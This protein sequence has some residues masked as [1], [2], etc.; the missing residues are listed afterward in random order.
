M[1]KK[2]GVGVLL[3]LL[4]G[5]STGILWANPLDLSEPYLLSWGG[6]LYDDWSLVVNIRPPKTIHPSYPATGSQKGAATWRCKE[7]HGWDYLG[8]AGRFAT[9]EHATGIR[10]I[11][12]WR[13]RDP[14]DVVALLRNAN[15]GYT[16]EMIS[17]AAAHALGL[18]VS[19]GQVEM[20]LFIDEKGKAK[21]DPERGK[22][23]FQTICAFCHGMDG[24]KINFGTEKKPEYLG[25][26]ARDNPWEVI[27]KMRHGEPGK[28][29]I[30]L[31]MLPELE[32][33]N[34][35]AFE[36]SLPE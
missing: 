27:H 17:D 36:Q 32:P 6:R 4:F 21:G 24:K 2:R 18:F 31:R 23:F 33:A 10:G 19:K 35:L 22:A 30:S 9:G 8:K 1:G 20:S 11:Q 16:P 25:D 29:M 26:A 14:A 28:E 3:G 12:A 34:I 15:H 5:W 13:G 7:C